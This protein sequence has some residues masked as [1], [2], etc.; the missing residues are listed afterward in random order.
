VIIPTAPDYWGFAG[1]TISKVND[2]SASDEDN[3]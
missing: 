3:Y 2:G 1:F